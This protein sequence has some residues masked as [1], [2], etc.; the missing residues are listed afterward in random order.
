MRRWSSLAPPR[1]LKSCGMTRHRELYLTP[2]QHPD[3]VSGW[4]THKSPGIP[5][6]FPS[7]LPPT[8]AV[9]VTHD[10]NGYVSVGKV[11][12]GFMDRVGSA[13]D[14]LPITLPTPAKAFRF[15]R[16]AMPQF[17]SRNDRSAWP[18][19]H[20]F[21][22]AAWTHPGVGSDCGTGAVEL[23]LASA[24]E[25]ALHHFARRLSPLLDPRVDRTSAMPISPRGHASRGQNLFFGS[26]IRTAPRYCRDMA[27][28]AS[29]VRLL[30]SSF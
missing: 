8:S 25:A 15:R 30:I 20:L 22:F 17:H 24:R 1:S 29:T 7:A 16:R 3:S 4:V 2:D 14:K 26:S 6:R 28:V 23:R 21:W 10:W 9:A 13:L 18:P 12:I 11:R 27:S 19:S 5:S